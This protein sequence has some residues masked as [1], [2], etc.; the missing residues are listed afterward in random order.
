[1][2]RIAE[3]SGIIILFLLIQIV[4]AGFYSM[5][6]DFPE[7]N[8]VAFLIIPGTISLLYLLLPFNTFRWPYRL[9]CMAISVLLTYIANQWH[10]VDGN[11]EWVLIAQVALFI[12]CMGLR[13]TAHRKRYLS[14][15]MLLCIVCSLGV[16]WQYW[17]ERQFHNANVCIVDEGRSC[18]A[19]GRCFQ[20]YAANRCDSNEVI[21]PLLF[22]SEEYVNIW[23]SSSEGV[24][25]MHFEGMNGRSK[26]YFLCGMGL[27]N[28]N[29]IGRI[30]CN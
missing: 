8:A 1:M 29:P 17:L 16:I 19:S 3:C 21:I 11:K 2:R 22:E 15:A 24:P 20:Y 18:G 10:L 6:S 12:A 30:Q 13:R 23:F 28:R 27:E 26:H 7:A 4:I 14:I 25:V 9:G 5:F